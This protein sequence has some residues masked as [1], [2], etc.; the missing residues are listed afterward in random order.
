M[1]DLNFAKTYPPKQRG[2]QEHIHLLK[3]ASIPLLC[4]KLL[5]TFLKEDYLGPS[6]LHW[7]Y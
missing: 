5:G 3:A 1:Y 7:L 4:A 6:L 2:N